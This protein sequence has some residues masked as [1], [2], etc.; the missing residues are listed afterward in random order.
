M[1]YI[2]RGHLITFW[3]TTCDVGTHEDTILD[4]W[5]TQRHNF[6]TVHLTWGHNFQFWDTAF[7]VGAL[8]WDTRG[9]NFGTLG[10]TILGHYNWDSIDSR[11]QHGPTL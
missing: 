1:S 2:C 8:F 5:N 7:D 3:D 6:G 9:H 11:I 4:F 10:D